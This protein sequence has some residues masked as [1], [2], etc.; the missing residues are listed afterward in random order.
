MAHSSAVFSTDL[1]RILKSQIDTISLQITSQLPLINNS[2]L[3]E[4]KAGIALLFAYLSNTFHKENDHKT[5][6]ELLDELGNSL[7]NEE[8]DYS[9]SGG[10]AGIGFTFQH[11]RN[12]GLL[13]KEEDM[14]LSEL[15]DFINLGIDRDFKNGNWD[16]LHGM[17]GLG[18]YFLERHKETGDEKYL[19]KIVNYLAKMR[20]DVKEHKVW[21]TPG[22]GKYSN[23]NYNFGMAHGMPG[24]LSFLAQV[25]ARGIKQ[26]EIRGMILSCLPF[27][28][29]YEYGEDEDH[30]FPTSIEIE[31][32]D[33]EQKQGSRLAW[34]YGD[35]CM[36]NALVHCGRVL[37]NDS[38]KTHGI[39]IALK[40]TKRNFESAGCLDAPF[41]H[42]SVGLVHQY[43]RFYH[44]TGNEVFKYAVD[45]W[46]NQTLKDH[47]K[48]GEGV[49]GYSFR[50]MNEHTNLFE[51]KPMY[52]LL[53]GGAGIALVWLYYLCDIK[54]D[55]DIVF[56]TNV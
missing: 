32:K 2:N 1:P 27:L 11:L 35:L 55:W 26:Q 47:Y 20:T 5:T 52:G 51:Y 13:N 19:E 10:V 56:L 40:T 46:V 21:I 48:P 22:Y 12:I 37:K 49:G 41:C 16:P 7:S 34:C 36:A 43:Q 6:I 42:G 15:D 45:A 8:L 14:N 54:P 50:Y 29:K 4:G 3:L 23:D 31:K 18:I 9:M 53:E 44:L 38:L 25:Y 28:L 39:N 17:V 24:I 33:E 30:C